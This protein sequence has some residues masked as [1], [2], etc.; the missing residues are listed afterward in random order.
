MGVGTVVL[1]CNKE[2]KFPYTLKRINL[3]DIVHESCVLALS[4]RRGQ[5]TKLLINK[6]DFIVEVPL[7]V[8]GGIW[9]KY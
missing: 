3:S 9:L 7:N 4:G 6:Y 8:F 5:F 2:G 1:N